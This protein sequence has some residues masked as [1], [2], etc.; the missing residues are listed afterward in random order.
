MSQNYIL[1][2]F[3]SLYVY[4]SVLRNIQKFINY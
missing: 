1:L 4:K 3:G 2:N